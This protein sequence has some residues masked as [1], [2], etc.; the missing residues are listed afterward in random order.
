M[1]TVVQGR[2]GGKKQLT[3]G[4]VKGEGVLKLVSRYKGKRLK[5]KCDKHKST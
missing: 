2:R 3:C 4:K 1:K 5:G